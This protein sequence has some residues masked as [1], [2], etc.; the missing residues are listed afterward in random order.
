[1]YLQVVEGRRPDVLIA[2]RYGY[3]APEL[4]TLLGE[5]PP[6]ERP[7]DA[8]EDRLFDKALSELD[9]P[10][11]S[12]NPRVSATRREVYEGLLYRYVRANET[13]DARLEWPEYHQPSRKPSQ[14]LGD[15][16]NEL[17]EYEYWSALGRRLL[18]ADEPQSAT[19]FFDY[20]ASMAR[21]DKTALNNIGIALASNGHVAKATEY[22]TRALD[23]DPDFVPALLNLAR[24][25][26]E[27][28]DSVSALALLERAANADADVDLVAKM[29]HAA[30]QL[31]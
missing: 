5:S 19:P 24:C 23:T 9:R 3:P 8:E 15:W 10:I 6:S 12:A 18:R 21:G 28:G 22:F 25:R 4:Y 11:Y 7:P 1:M 26:I 30:L 16:S 13:Y 31:Q 17:V 20:A 14:S 29:K 27:T 2:N